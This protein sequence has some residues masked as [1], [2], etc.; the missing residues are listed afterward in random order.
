ML[1]W[2]CFFFF[3]F[4]FFGQCRT[5]S[6]QKLCE[7]L[8]KFLLN[9]SSKLCRGRIDALALLALGKGVWGSAFNQSLNQIPRPWPTDSTL[10][11]WKAARTHGV[12]L[13][14]TF[15]QHHANRYIWAHG[16]FAMCLNK[17]NKDS[18]RCTWRSQRRKKQ[19]ESAFVDLRHR[20]VG[21]YAN[22]PLSGWKSK[23]LGAVKSA[24]SDG[25]RDKLVS[26]P[27][28]FELP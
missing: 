16:S 27:L 3:F 18:A 22:E 14:Q 11:R 8:A 2:H 1:A 15:W 6:A 17:A 4:F 13:F 23:P 19:L 28:D 7:C 9:P 10:S 26:Q 25:E 20:P 24:L 5:S 12:R 21:M